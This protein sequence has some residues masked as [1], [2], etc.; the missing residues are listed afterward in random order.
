MPVDNKLL[1]DLARMA[2]G[3]LGAL[4]NLREEA[5]ARLRQQFEQILSRMDIV[6]REEYE[7]VQAMAAKARTE[8]ETLTERVTTLEATVAT[9]L[10]ER[11]LSHETPAPRRVPPAQH[12]PASDDAPGAPEAS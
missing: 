2:G 6:T 11:T 1:D 10:A 7:A 8:Q 12:K 9:L 3:A 5:E 4:S